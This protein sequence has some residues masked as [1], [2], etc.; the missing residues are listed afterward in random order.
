[1]N[2]KTEMMMVAGICQS[3]KLTLLLAVNFDV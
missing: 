1:M 2:V 3:C